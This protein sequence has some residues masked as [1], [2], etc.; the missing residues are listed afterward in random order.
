MNELALL[1]VQ[2]RVARLTLNRPEKRNA[3]SIDLL[4]ALHG[5]VDELARLAGSDEGP[6]VCVVTGAGPS[7]CSGMDLR[8][9]MSDP[10]LATQLLN[11]LAELTI[12]LRALPVVT[13][14][15]VNGA[16]IG[17]GCGLVAVCDIAVTHADSK[18]GYPE[19]DLGVCP[20]VVAPWLVRAV[21]SSTAR[22]ILLQG[23]TMSGQRAFE[24]G[25][26]AES[27]ETGMLDQRVEE[28]VARLAKAGP[29]ALRATKGLINEMDGPELAAMVRRGA[30]LSAQVI[31]GPEA[32]RMLRNVLGA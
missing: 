30:I 17:G 2:G 15:R 10:A 29:R 4:E 32:Q 6:V 16:A 18:L 21:G 1:D 22:R 24:M 3:L 23:G 27:T 31:G 13:V 5:R 9:V 14:A 20:A 26:V 19:V 28:I 25:L 8:A 7:F 12:K 11:L